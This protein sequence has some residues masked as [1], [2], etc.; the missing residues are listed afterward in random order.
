MILHIKQP[1]SVQNEV[2][3]LRWQNPFGHRW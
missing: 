2:L 3:P 1:S